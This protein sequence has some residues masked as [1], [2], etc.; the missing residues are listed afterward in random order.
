MSKRAKT[1]LSVV[2]SVALTFGLCPAAYADPAESEMR[3]SDSIEFG[4]AI[5][6][7]E[8]EWNKIVEEESSV[9][10]NVGSGNEESG[11]GLEASNSAKN[12]GANERESNE[13]PK[14]ETETINDEVVQTEPLPDSSTLADATSQD[15][16]KLV[17]AAEQ[18][19][20]DGDYLIA[21]SICDNRVLDV[22]GGSRQDSASIQTFTYNGLAAQKWRISHDENGY[23]VISNIGSGKVLDV[24]GAKKQNGAQI[25]TH[26]TGHWLS[27]GCP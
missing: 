19:I 11:F 9:E 14:D 24:R 4:E 22:R 12:S 7:E 6:N 27:A 15:E 21:S 3:D 17:Q 13:S 23:L 20:P 5:G 26:P 8:T 25:N 16:R 1:L 10:D 2:V 18:D